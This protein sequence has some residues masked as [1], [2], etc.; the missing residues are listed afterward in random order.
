[1]CECDD[2]RE[3]LFGKAQP[4]HLHRGLFP[5]VARHGEVALER[6]RSCTK[7]F[8][9]CAPKNQRIEHLIIEGKVVGLDEVDCRSPLK[10]GGRPVLG[11]WRLIAPSPLR[12]SAVFAPASP[13]E[14]TA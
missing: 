5:A 6:H 9:R 12:H 13:F 1:M 7:S 4:V 11:L 2:L 14:Q 8:G 3:L 10:C